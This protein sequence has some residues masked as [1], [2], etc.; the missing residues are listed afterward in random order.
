MC[1]CVCPCVDVFG[2]CS[3]AP[4]DTQHEELCAF[5]GRGTCDPL[6]DLS[7]CV[8]SGEGLCLGDV[9]APISTWVMIYVCEYD[10]DNLRVCT[11]RKEI[12]ETVCML[13]HLGKGVCVPACG[14]TGRTWMTVVRWRHTSVCE[15]LGE[16]RVPGT[17][18]SGV[19]AVGAG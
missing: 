12:C 18:V 8:H 6:C 13:V 19:G 11:I 7:W 9:C 1:V 17:Q 14:L 16:G 15:Q 2:V 4:Q 3:Y 10:C 5:S